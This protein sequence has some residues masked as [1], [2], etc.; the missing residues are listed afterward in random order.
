M[1]VRVNL[2]PQEQTARQAA[3]RQRNGVIAG[4]VA[5]LAI[6]GAVT[7]WQNG[8]VSEAEDRLAAEQTVLAGLQDEERQLDEFADLERRVRRVRRADRRPRR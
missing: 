5:V 2:L 8:R 4:G 3:A 6:L 1:S 7:V